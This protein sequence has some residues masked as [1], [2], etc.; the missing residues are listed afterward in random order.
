MLA[1][2]SGV[3]PVMTSG[4]SMS[5]SAAVST[6]HIAGAPRLIADCCGQGELVIFLHGIGGN[7]SNWRAQL[8]SLSD[9]LLTVAYD[10]RGYGDSDDYD[11]PLAMCDLR[12]DLARVLDH[13]AARQAHLVGLSM[14]GMVALDFVAHYPDRVRSLVL[15]DTS[16]GPAQD[17]SAVE[18]E[19]FLRL[20][21]APLEAG[22]SPVDIAASV[23]A[24][25][26]APDCEQ[27]VRCELEASI[28][29]LHRDSYLK[30]LDM[31]TRHRDLTAAAVAGRPT[32]VIVGTEDRLTPPA[33]VRDFAA[34]IPGARFVEIRGAGHLSNLERPAEFNRALQ[35]F[36][37]DMG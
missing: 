11:G 22:Q 31:I 15:A 37:T 17:F 35:H 32:L 19:D 23:A 29:R 8:E 27:A 33:R 24:S 20:R 18:I 1:G 7:R 4:L 5:D 13:F 34:T 21:R 10:S 9:R 14:G 36:Y 25:L 6:V 16:L 3:I 12:T 28:A 2:L 26:V 30:T